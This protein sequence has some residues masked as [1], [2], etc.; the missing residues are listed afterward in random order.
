M[1]FCFKIAPIDRSR[2]L[3]NFS[4]QELFQPPPDEKVMT[5]QT[6]CGICVTGDANSKVLGVKG[7]K[8]PDRDL[9]KGGG[10]T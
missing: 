10:Q 7:L 9:Q 2:P 4:T 1:T 3:D 6:H 8:P 5:D